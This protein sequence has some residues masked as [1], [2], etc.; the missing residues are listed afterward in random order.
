[1]VAI[2]WGLGAGLAD[3][4]DSSHG[5]IADS[6]PALLTQHRSFT[7][8]TDNN[9]HV[10]PPDAGNLIAGKDAHDCLGLKSQDGRQVKAKQWWP[11]LFDVECFVGVPFNLS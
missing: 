3:Y 11:A 7:T 10:L 4:Y 2:A 5:S 6:L 8:N 9:H 1:M